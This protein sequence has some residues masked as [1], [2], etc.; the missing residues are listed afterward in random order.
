MTL[1]SFHAGKALSAAWTETNPPPSRTKA[2]KPARHG[3][4]QGAPLYVE[5]TSR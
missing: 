4:D 1:Y 5:T 3:S 2:S